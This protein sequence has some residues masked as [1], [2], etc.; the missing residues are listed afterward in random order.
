MKPFFIVSMGCL[1]LVLSFG[2]KPSATETARKTDSGTATSIGKKNVFAATAKENEANAF[3]L[4]EPEAPVVAEVNDDASRTN[5]SSIRILAWNIESDGANIDVIAQQLTE[6]D[7]YDIYGFT[8]VMPKE[9]PAIKESLGDGY[10]FWYSKTGYDDRT[11]FAISKQR[12]AVIKKYEL[13]RF[14][15]KSLNPGNYRSPHV[16]ELED[17]VT[18]KKF[19]IMLNHL[20]RGKAEVRQEQAEGLRRWGRSMNLPV[21]AIGDYNF[22][23]VFETAKGNKAFD[24]FMAD[25]TFEWVKP[26]PLID[27]NWFD[28]DRDGVDDYPGSIL[29]FAFVAGEAKTWSPISKVIVRGGDFPDDDQTSDHRPIELIVTPK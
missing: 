2:C 12:F 9:W 8:E 1:L 29:D 13:G 7:S 24:L 25:D 4:S 23:Y 15:D 3:D 16:Y 19:A 5:D 10:V 18:G 26:E 22:D 27:S 6:L 11:A 17:K 20:A 28:G 21:I 14:E